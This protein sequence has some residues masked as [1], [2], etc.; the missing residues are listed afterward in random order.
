[1]KFHW[2]IKKEPCL[3]TRLESQTLAMY[4]SSDDLYTQRMTAWIYNERINNHEYGLI[5]F[6]KSESLDIQRRI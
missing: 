2:I 3:Y 1:M 5:I 6:Q 4:S